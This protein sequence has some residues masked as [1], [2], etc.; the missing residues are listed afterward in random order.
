L[1]DLE[2]LLA[3]VNDSKFIPPPLANTVF[4]GI[5]QDAAVSG[6]AMKSLL[7]AC[8]AN[9]NDE[10]IDDIQSLTPERTH[11]ATGVRDY[12]IDVE[13]TTTSG[14]K[15]YVDV[16]LNKFSAMIRRS[17]LY[18]EQGLAGE[19]YKGE[20]IH[21]VAANMPRVL[22]VNILD[23]V[24][25]KFEPNFHQIVEL[26]YRTPP[27]ERADDILAIH[28]I[29]L[30]RFR[31]ITPDYGNPFH[32]WLLGLTKAQDQ[33]IFLK[34]IIE[35]DLNLKEYYETDPGFAQFVERHSQVASDPEI[36]KAYK[37]WLIHQITEREHLYRSA[38][39]AIDEAR[40]A[41]IAEARP[42][43][44]AAAIANRDMEY[45]KLEF[46]SLEPGDDIS[47][48]FKKLSNLRVPKDVIESARMQVEAERGKK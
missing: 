24:L 29:Q 26:F 21:H 20:I 2:K 28:N 9:S 13:A 8:L 47:K 30:P 23:F 3:K 27:H 7:N 17:L 6:L 32:C 18:A 38:Q 44:E 5:F 14:T 46:R 48:V 31:A 39:V 35:M 16:Q 15:L 45:A 19:A 12:R 43:I 33:N 36:K 4:T 11:T 42:A 1:D 40:P 34:E 41:I 22:V 37:Y 10:P 25:R